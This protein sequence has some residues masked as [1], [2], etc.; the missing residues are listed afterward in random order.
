MEMTE[1]TVS[2]ISV[3]FFQKGNRN[4]NRQQAS[5]FTEE[6]GWSQT[7]SELTAWSFQQAAGSVRLGSDAGRQVCELADGGELR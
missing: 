1:V 4:R 3:W 6:T 2:R 7:G 5:S